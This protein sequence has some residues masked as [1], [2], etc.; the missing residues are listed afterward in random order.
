M[1]CMELFAHIVLLD[2]AVWLVAMM[3]QLLQSAVGVTKT[4]LKA[5]SGQAL[6]CTGTSLFNKCFR[7]SKPLSQ[8]SDR[9]Q[10]KNTY[11]TTE[12]DFIQFA[13]RWLWFWYSQHQWAYTIH[14]VTDI[15][16]Q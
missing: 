16:L 9:F 13:H 6:R 15:N 1:C 10:N 5:V 4:V 11:I 2:P 14:F 3:S 12:E 8:H 7:S